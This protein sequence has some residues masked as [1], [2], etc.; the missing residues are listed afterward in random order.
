MAQ[1]GGL[2]ARGRPKETTLKKKWV[3]I[4]PD[5]GK[6]VAEG[7]R[8]RGEFGVF[9]WNKKKNYVNINER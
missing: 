8:R 9:A 6:K 1:D 7:G 4:N 2:A 3:K 5:L